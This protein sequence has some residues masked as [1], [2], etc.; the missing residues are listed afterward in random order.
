MQTLLRAAA[1]PSLKPQILGT[2]NQYYTA[3]NS[4]SAG[5]EQSK[6]HAALT[7]SRLQGHPGS[8]PAA[9]ILDPAVQ[10]TSHGSR[11]FGAWNVLS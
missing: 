2:P 5:R 11:R 7:C 8:A 1:F 6:M 4:L 9:D 10:I 3:Q